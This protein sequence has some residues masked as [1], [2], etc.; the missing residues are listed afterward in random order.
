MGKSAELPYLPSAKNV[1]ALFEKI[2]A[3]KVPNA[4]THNVLY[5]T[6]GLKSVGD[7]AF[8]SLLKKLSF[9]DPSGRPTTSY[10]R[11]KN[12]REVKTAIAEGVRKA[13]EPLFSANENVFELDSGDLKGLVAQV[14]GADDSVVKKITS[15]FLALVKLGD[16]NQL[17]PAKGDEE[18]IEKPLPGE[19][20]KK[21]PLAI[22][23]LGSGFHFNIQIHLPSNAT[24]ETYINIFSGIRK[25]FK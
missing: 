25:V 2:K 15:T 12:D 11:L 21:N 22:G 5:N 14:T 9:L 24:E 18:A 17:A 7:R 4:I 20:E 6:F 19:D 13:Y 1:S 23:S 8:I 10:A 3:A 16:F